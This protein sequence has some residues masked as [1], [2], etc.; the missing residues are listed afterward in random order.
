MTSPYLELRLRS[1]DEAVEDKMLKDLGH[2]HKD[3][4]L[5]N[6]RADLKGENVFRLGRRLTTKIGAKS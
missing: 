4:Q 1:L 2:R 5:A 6:K 3:I